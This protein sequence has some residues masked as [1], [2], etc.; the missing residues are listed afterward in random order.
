MQSHGESASPSTQSYFTSF[1]RNIISE[2]SPK[3]L[4]M[5]LYYPVCVYLGYHIYMIIGKIISTKP[6]TFIGQLLLI[7][8]YIYVKY[9]DT[10][11]HEHQS[12][13]DFDLKDIIP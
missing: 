8:A 1:F 10:L 5:P 6:L 11:Y 13:T 4:C 7:S 12:G 3:S 2:R 9:K